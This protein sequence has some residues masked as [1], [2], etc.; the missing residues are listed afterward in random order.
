MELKVLHRQMDS[1]DPLYA[2]AECRQLF[3]IYTTY[4]AKTG[5]CLPWVAYLVILDNE[6]AGCCS[7]TTP[8]EGGKVEIS[9]W[10]FSAYEGRGVASFGCRS[11]IA[12]AHQTD[13]GI[14]ITA[15]TA[16]AKNASTSILQKNGFV[17]SGIVQDDEIGDAWLWVLEPRGSSTTV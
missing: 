7:F 8:P 12:I 14:I 4:Y 5:F 9:Y 15:K 13:P 2:S 10:T 16:P 17:C 1:S 3:N 6:V 11:L